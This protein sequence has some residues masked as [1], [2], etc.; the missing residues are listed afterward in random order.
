MLKLKPDDFRAM[1]IGE[2]ALAMDG[3]L[4][5]IGAKKKGATWNDV[6]EAEAK[7]N[8]KV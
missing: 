7:A 1:S 6:L 4:M 5:S 2:F 8:G 3:H